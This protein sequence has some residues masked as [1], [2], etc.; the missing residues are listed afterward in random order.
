[1]E[2]FAKQNNLDFYLFSGFRSYN[3]QQKLW[4][5][6]HFISNDFLALP[7]FSEHQTGL[8]VDVACLQTG[9][10]RYFED[11]LEFEF[12]LN[13]AHK[14][15]FILRYPKDKKDITGYEYEPWHYRYVGV[16]VA[17]ICYEENLTLEEYFYKYLEIPISN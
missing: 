16:D 13:N 1:M 10:T 8:A 11:T 14:F 3:K 12:L 5:A 6:N 7:G 4:E 2:I 9:L 15:G 17:R